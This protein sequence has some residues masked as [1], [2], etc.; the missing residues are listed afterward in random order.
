MM[1]M[2]LIEEKNEDEGG[3]DKI[4]VDKDGDEIHG[5]NEGSNDEKD[6]DADED[7]GDDYKGG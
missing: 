4:H 5:D 2:M 6:I 3:I 1:K 7:E